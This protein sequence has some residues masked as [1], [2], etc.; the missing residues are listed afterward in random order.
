LPTPDFGSDVSTF[1]AGDLDPSFNLIT[2]PHV[3][4]ENIARRLS[5]T[6]G[7]MI[8]DPNFGLNLRD[9]L[10][11]A[12]TPQQIFAL[13]KSVEAECEK[14]DRV[15]DASAQLTYTSVAGGTLR[16]SVVFNT[17]A[18]PFALDLSVSA[19]TPTLITRP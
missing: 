8:D 10:N 6:R 19:L 18:G 15:L 1:V 2:G 7:T 12:M 9:F 16:V 3:V 4:A 17:S 5:T 14:D 13:Q 11:S